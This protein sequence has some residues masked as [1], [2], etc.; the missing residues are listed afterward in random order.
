MIVIIV[1]VAVWIGLTALAEPDLPDFETS[2]EPIELPAEGSFPVVS[3]TEFEGLLV[4]LQGT[5]Q[6][7]TCDSDNCRR[8]H[9]DE[10][11]VEFRTHLATCWCR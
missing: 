4:G 6:R 1:I 10:L 2:G 7:R 3:T 9:A 8:Y 5:R 11:R